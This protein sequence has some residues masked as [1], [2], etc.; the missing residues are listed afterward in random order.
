MAATEMDVKQLYGR[1][2]D[3]IRGIAS[4]GPADETWEFMCE[5]SDVKCREK[6]VL[7]LTEFD[8]RRA[9][10]PPGPILAASHAAVA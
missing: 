10:T 1:V 8:D 6:V 5:C 9:A 2:N 4:E 3:S 7:T